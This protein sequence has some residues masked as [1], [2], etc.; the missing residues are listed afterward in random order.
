MKAKRSNWKSV[1]GII[2]Y[3]EKVNIDVL[4]RRIFEKK[5]KKQIQ[6]RIIF[7]SAL[8]SVGVISY[9]AG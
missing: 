1:N 4:R 7:V 9:F 5:K 8:V 3:K 2:S 6:N